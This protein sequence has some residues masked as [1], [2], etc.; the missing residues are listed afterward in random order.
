MRQKM[1]LLVMAVVAVVAFAGCA[2]DESTDAMKV[3]D[4]AVHDVE[5]ALVRYVQIDPNGPADE[6]QRATDQ[7]SSAWSGLVDAA[8]DVETVDISDAQAAYDELVAAASE[9]TEDM[10][11][12]EAFESVKSK[13][14]AFEE[15][16]EKLHEDMD[17][18]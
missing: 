12:A 9:I 18:H 6:V 10:T 1:V 14:D 13:V 15:A 11:A 3:L 4:D 16:V 17:V 7:V 8:G 2:A 5:R